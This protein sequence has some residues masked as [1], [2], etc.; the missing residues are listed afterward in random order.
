MIQ[1]I[2]QAQEKHILRLQ[3]VAEKVPLKAKENIDRVIGKAQLKIENANSDNGNSE[4]Q[5]SDN[6]QGS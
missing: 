5:G 6:G 3:D 4:D 1:T 2:V